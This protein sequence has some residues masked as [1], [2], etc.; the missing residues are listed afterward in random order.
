MHCD[1][2]CYNATILQYI[3]DQGNIYNLN[4]YSVICQ[5]CSMKKDLTHSQANK[6]K[7]IRLF[8]IWIYIYYHYWLILL[9]FFKQFF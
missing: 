3:N 6:L 8:E 2:Y 9:F 5:M 4:L 7:L 1:K